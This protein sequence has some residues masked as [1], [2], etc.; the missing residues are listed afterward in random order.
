MLVKACLN[1]GTTREQHPAVPLTPEE[2]AADARAVVEAGAGALHIHPRD[3]DGAETLDAACTTA[4]VHA[5]RE[6]CAGVPVG[7]STGLWMAEGDPDRRLALIRSWPGVARPDFASVNLS[8]PGYEELAR[9]LGEAG[10]GVE[11]GVWTTEDAD[12]LG[13]SPMAVHLVRVLVEPRDEDGAAA[14]RTAAAVEG[15]L[16]ARGVPGPRLLH[17]Y[18]A[19]TW[20]VIREA[21]GLGRDLRV[22]LEDTT[23]LPDGRRCEGNLDL[24]E[25]AVALTGATA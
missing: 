22:G 10:I 13:G 2:L 5:V 18:G 12:R 14:V 25:A 4:A 3:S 9:V 20:Q 24:V 15:A 1:G 7:V 11:A 19:A 23:E 17:G 21:I 8:E 16:D 6:A